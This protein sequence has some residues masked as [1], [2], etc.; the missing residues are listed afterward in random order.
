M[1][2]Q[3]YYTRLT[4]IG[5]ARL[6][7]A[8][9]DEAP[10]G[11][12]QAA[13]GDGGG[14]SYDPSPDQT[15]LVGEWHRRPVNRITVDPDN[16]HWVVIEVVVP[17]SVG[18]HYVRE[19]GLI[20]RD[21]A[22]I[23]IAKFPPT[24]KP[25]LIAGTG[26]DLVI[27]V[28]LEVANAG[29]VE[30]L[31]DPTVVTA[32]RAYVDQ[33]VG[34]SAAAL[35]GD[36]E[37]AIAALHAARQELAATTGDYRLA[38]VYP[39]IESSGGRLPVSA[40]HGAI[41]AGAGSLVHRGGRR[42]A[43]A[44]QTFA[45][46]PNRT[47]HLRWLA[48]GQPDAPEADWPQG[49]LVLRDLADPAYNPS[50]FAEDHGV[51][52]TRYDDALLARIV[53]TA[54]NIPVATPLANRAHLTA[55]LSGFFVSNDP[56]GRAHFAILGGSN[57]IRAQCP[58]PAYNWSRTPSQRGHRGMVGWSNG[59][60]AVEPSVSGYANHLSLA[61][62]T[63]YSALTNGVTDYRGAD[64][65]FDPLRDTLIASCEWMFAA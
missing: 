15:A 54:A 37:A 42:L 6:A 3:E 40:E 56:A 38:P 36:L 58:S 24:Y 27:R 44:P 25:T 1:P 4:D 20:D 60:F 59:N 11:I 8:L 32:S 62:V 49:R 21:G 51:F 26:S 18:G 46:A 61:S 19:V 28:I 10:L 55:N 64:G 52:D 23:A 13:L 7:T 43:L 17:M 31:I 53:T 14:T 33:M 63:R 47:C 48:P 34:Q 29:S 2:E 65:P 16:P 22:L 57:A 41:A 39:E 35:R 50:G 30:L 45:T 5:R 9:A 12:A